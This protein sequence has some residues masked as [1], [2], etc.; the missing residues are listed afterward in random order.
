MGEVYFIKDPNAVDRLFDAAGLGSIIPKNE[1]VALKIHFGETGNTAYIKPE[2]ARPIAKKVKEF[3][4]DPFWTDANTLYKGTRKDS[5]AHLQTAYDHGYTLE[6][7]GARVVIADGPEGNGYEKIAVN[8]KHQKELFLAPLV[9]DA[10]ALIAVTH[11]KGHELTGFGGALK[12]VGM[13]LGSRAGKLEMHSDCDHCK[14]RTSCRKKETLEACWV[15]SPE[16]VQEKMVEYAAGILGRFNKKYAFINFITDVSPNCDCYGHNDP[17]IVPDIGI[18]A[19]FD[20]VAIDQAS[21]DMVN[22]FKKPW[23]EIN[24]ETQLR[25]A[26]EIGLGSRKYELIEIGPDQ[27]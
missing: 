22:I 12:N 7:S 14:A 1:Q 15:G 6:R 26:E 25:Y 10:V 3:G 2:R 17:P 9:F 21:V 16:M 13:G 20:P 11:F 27:R 23:P 19:S 8:F 5:P 4:G 24:W 18:L